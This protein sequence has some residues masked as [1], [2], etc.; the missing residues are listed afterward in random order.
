[1]ISS[2]ERN[3]TSLSGTFMRSR[4][5]GSRDQICSFLRYLSQDRKVI[6][7]ALI[8]PVESPSFARSRRK[9]SISFFV[10][11]ST[12]IMQISLIFFR[13]SRF[14]HLFDASV[15]RNTERWI[16]S[17]SHRF[18]SRN[19]K[20]L[21]RWNSYCSRVRILL[22]LWSRRYVRKFSREVSIFILHIVFI[23]E[24]KQYKNTSIVFMEVFSW[25]F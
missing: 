9:L 17:Y 13:R 6:I 1:M 7:W 19:R 11:S 8:D 12:L 5:V 22:P 15:S 4:I 20:S 21:Q 25:I 23:S 2:F 3:V 16:V 24:R 10:I 14:S 18:T